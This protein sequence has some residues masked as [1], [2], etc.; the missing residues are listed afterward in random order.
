MMDALIYNIMSVIVTALVTIGLFKLLAKRKLV[1]SSLSLILMDGAYALI[2][3]ASMMFL[4]QA[5]LPQNDV[6]R[7]LQ[8]F[9]F[10]FCIG[11]I[12]IVIFGIWLLISKKWNIHFQDTGMILV[13]YIKLFI[14]LYIMIWHILPSLLS[15]WITIP[16]Y[17]IK[18][19]DRILLFILCSIGLLLEMF[20]IRQRN[21]QVFSYHKGLNQQQVKTYL[22]FMKHSRHNSN[23]L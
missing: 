6:W 23:K 4:I 20:S 14:L 2:F 5:I 21:H 11:I 10:A 3:F 12:C 1:A 16:V 18:D 9:G 17:D 15:I 19:S 13:D 22:S 8:A 7:S